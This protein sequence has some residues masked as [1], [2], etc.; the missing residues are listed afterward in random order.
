MTSSRVW[1]TDYIS[2]PTIEREILGSSLA[3]IPSEDVEVLLV[4]HQSIDSAYLAHFPKLKA[5]IRFGVGFDNLDLNALQERGIVACNT[6]D[7]GVDEVSDSAIAMILDATRGVSR[8]DALCR[9]YRETWQENTLATAKRSSQVVVGVLG[10]GRIGG[11]V[12][13]KARAIGYQTLFCDPYRPSGHEKMLGARRVESLDELL[14]HSDVVSLHVPLSV[15]TRAMVNARFIS[16]MKCGACLVN[17]ARGALLD[18]LDTLYDPLHSGHLGAVFLD[19]LP[20]EPPPAKGR[21][22]EAWRER[23][24]WLAGRLI[25]NPHSAYY[26]AASFQ[27]MRSKAALNAKRVL[28]GREP[29]NILAPPSGQAVARFR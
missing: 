2:D 19:V 10:A 8:Y 28:E 18:E 14:A 12:L 24:P 13:L 16:K 7:Y 1:I 22:I 29:L 23:A 25:I 4:W 6:P 11:S 5:V 17:T 26:S 9:T 3:D 20:D 21:L 27:E 15:E